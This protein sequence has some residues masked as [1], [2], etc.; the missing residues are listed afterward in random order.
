MIRIKSFP[1]AGILLLLAGCCSLAMGGDLKPFRSDG[2]SDFPNGTYQQ[3]KLW[4]RCCYQHDLSYWQGGTKLQRLVADH[5]LEQCVRSVGEPAIAK[6]MLAGVRVGGS[7]YWP[8][9]FRWG[10]G[11]PYMRGYKTLSADE[12]RQV[13]A[14]LKR[15]APELASILKHPTKR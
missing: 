7:P 8:T 11:W 15:Q 6:L 12:R 14:M 13:E 2:C 3:R 10:Y 1:R 5:D 4:L 9:S